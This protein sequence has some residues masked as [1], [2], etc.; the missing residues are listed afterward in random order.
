MKE[1]KKE[2]DKAGFPYWWDSE[3]VG[4]LIVK[5]SADESEIH[6][7]VPAFQPC[8][9]LHGDI[10]YVWRVFLGPKDGEYEIQCFRIAHDWEKDQ[11]KHIEQVDWQAKA[12]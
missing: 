5:L 7:S 6:K 11:I 1:A 3:R 8:L 12:V 2:L 4:A 10:D 9:D